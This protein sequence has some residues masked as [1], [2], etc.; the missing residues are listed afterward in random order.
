MLNRRIPYAIL[1]VNCLF[2]GL[3]ISADIMTVK[4]SMNGLRSVMQKSLRVCPIE[5]SHSYFVLVASS[6]D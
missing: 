1:I 6:Y 2:A 4:I 3:Q 5:A